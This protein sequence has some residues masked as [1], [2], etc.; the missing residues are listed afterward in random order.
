MKA[1]GSKTFFVSSHAGRCSS[2]KAVLRYFDC[3]SVT[4]DSPNSSGVSDLSSFSPST[5]TSPSWQPVIRT[6][7]AFERKMPWEDGPECKTT[8]GKFILPNNAYKPMQGASA[9]GAQSWWE[10][11]NFPELLFP[12]IFTALRCYLA[13]LI[14]LLFL[15]HP[16]SILWKE[17][18]KNSKH[19]NS[20]R[21]VTGIF[22]LKKL[23]WHQVPKVADF[24]G[25]HLLP[26]A[27]CT[28]LDTF[29]ICLRFA[30]KI[31][32]CTKSEYIHVSPVAAA[33][34]HLPSHLYIS[35]VFLPCRQPPIVHPICAC[36][37]QGPA[38]AS[39]GCL[40]QI[41][42]VLHHLCNMLECYITHQLLPVF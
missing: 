32:I 17:K 3:F 31:P 33:K 30:N 41:N 29:C 1:A 8:G 4:A 6:V 36:W 34:C 5:Y 13:Q 23:R 15:E 16:I 37:V 19:M 2:Q 20:H 7:K 35:G 25:T 42:P 38:T 28:S 22:R 10:S 24:P 39:A 26:H 21:K 40:L 14:S 11:L 18:S 9:S 12:S 27:I